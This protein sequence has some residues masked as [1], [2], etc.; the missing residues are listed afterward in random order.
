MNA[1]TEVKRISKIG[2]ARLGI[3]KV[4]H[5]EATEHAYVST[6]R[7]HLKITLCWERNSR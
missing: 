3:G 2:V 1:A 6:V 4:S 7:K 5:R